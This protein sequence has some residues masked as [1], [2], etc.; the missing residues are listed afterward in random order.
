[1]NI[2]CQVDLIVMQSINQWRFSLFVYKEH[3]TKCIQLFKAKTVKE[4]TTNILDIFCI[5]EAPVLFYNGR[6]FVNIIINELKIMCL[7]LRIVHGK[8]HHS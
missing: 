1:M 8:P 3:V 5:F 4:V 2:H 7:T 6:Q